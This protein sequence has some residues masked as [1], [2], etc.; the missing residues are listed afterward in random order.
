MRAAT[1]TSPSVGGRVPEATDI[2]APSE[3][4][5]PDVH[6]LFLMWTGTLDEVR[7][8]RPEWIGLDKFQLRGAAERILD[9]VNDEF[10]MPPGEG[11][12]AI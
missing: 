5:M 4:D 2:D 12:G 8:I 6:C 1:A 7:D 10:F 3:R 9:Y 11:D